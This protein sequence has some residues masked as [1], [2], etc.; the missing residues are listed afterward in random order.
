MRTLF[1]VRH[2][3]TDWNRESRLQGRALTE[4]NDRG[5]RQSDATG[6]YLDQYWDIDA[7]YSSPLPRA[8]QTAEI[9]A[10]RCGVGVSEQ[11]AGLVE[12][13]WGGLQG[14]LAEDV[15]GDRPEYSMSENGEDALNVAPP[16]GE[17][18]EDVR[19]RALDAWRRV[20][21]RV[22]NGGRAVV[23]SHGIPIRFIKGH[24]KGLAP[25]RG[26][27][28]E[29]SNASVTIIRVDDG[30]FSVVEDDFQPF[31]PTGKEKY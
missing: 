13:D 15:F 18:Y 5:R 24:L 3:E 27:V 11:F 14:F 28:Q 30:E 9:I 23:V 25:S 17:S 6:A 20:V 16:G 4:L 1:L 29:V 26:V 31:T 2:G 21:G 19:D 8:S 7:V 12:R 10:D 22:E